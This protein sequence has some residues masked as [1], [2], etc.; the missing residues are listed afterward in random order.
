V[1]PYNSLCCTSRRVY[2]NQLLCCTLTCLFFRASICLQELLCFSW[3]CL[4]DC[5]ILPVYL[6]P[7]HV[8][9]CR[10]WKYLSTRACAAPVVVCPQ[11]LLCCIWTCL[12]TRS[13]AAPVRQCTCAFWA[14]PG[15]AGQKLSLCFTTWMSTRALCGT[16]SCTVKR[17]CNVFRM[18]LR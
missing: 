12:S 10:T 8:L 16:W 5:N 17:F 13:C 15:H 9:L 18:M 14:V 7:V 1:C 11:E 2:L 4:R 3:T 6:V